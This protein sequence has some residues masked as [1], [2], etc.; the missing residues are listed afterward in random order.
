[1]KSVSVPSTLRQAQGPVVQSPVIEPVEMPGEKDPIP[2]LR[3]A[4]GP[5]V[6]SP[7][8]EL[9]ETPVVM[10]RFLA[11]RFAKVEQGFVQ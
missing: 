10:I 9:V 11:F 7:V 4:Q 1:M 2:T 8:V 5:V 6:Q 3:Q